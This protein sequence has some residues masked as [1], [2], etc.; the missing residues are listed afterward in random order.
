M[1]RLPAES[2]SPRGVLP[3][4]SCGLG[5]KPSQ[6]SSQMPAE[7]LK[8]QE[9]PPGFEPGME[10]LQ[11]SALPLGYGTDKPSP[12]VCLRHFPTLPGNTHPECS[13][14]AG[15]R[16]SARRRSRQ[17]RNILHRTRVWN[18]GTKR[19]DQRLSGREWRGR[20]SHDTPSLCLIP[21]SGPD[22][23]RSVP[24]LPQRLVSP[25][26]T[27]DSPRPLID[28]GHF[29]T[30]GTLNVPDHPLPDRGR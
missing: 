22:H 19:H 29:A 15:D 9:V 21:E 8:N 1:L 18:P 13:P 25:A 2:S 6:K 20:P 30:P 24:D 14:T 10:V 7:D 5:N 12:N 11:T 17:A 26:A 3:S 27:A 23:Q 16:E 28:S 4:Q